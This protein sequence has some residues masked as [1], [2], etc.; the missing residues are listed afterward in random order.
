LTTDDNYNKQNISA[1]IVR[2]N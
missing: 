1:E 2:Y